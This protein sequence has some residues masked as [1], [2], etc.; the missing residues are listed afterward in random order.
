MTAK[1]EN[2][3]RNSGVLYGGMENSTTNDTK[4]RS[5]KNH[6]RRQ[7]SNSIPVEEL[8]FWAKS[9]TQIARV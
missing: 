9:G 8:R 5:D 1:T 2:F 4:Q 3:N 7:M 6:H